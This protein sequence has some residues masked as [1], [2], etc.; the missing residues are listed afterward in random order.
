M[1]SRLLPDRLTQ[2]LFIGYLAIGAFVLVV[3][4]TVFQL[5]VL[6]H[7]TLTLAATLAYFT[8]AATHF[9][10][11]RY[12]N[13]RRFERAIHEQAR[14]FTVVIGAQWLITL[15]VVTFLTA[16]G[17]LPI[18]SRFVAVIVNLPL[19]FVA[20]RYLTFGDGILPVVARLRK[21]H[22]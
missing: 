13:F 7:V 19:G 17:I 1:F 15:I 8:G 12:A 6:R 5:C 18:L 16:H 22:S 21:A 3:D 10:L 20:N 9:M 14:T 11:N 2:G 4:F